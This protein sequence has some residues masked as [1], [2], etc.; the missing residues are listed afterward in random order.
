MLYVEFTCHIIHVMLTGVCG[1]AAVEQGQAVCGCAVI[2]VCVKCG[3]VCVCMG[4]GDKQLYGEG[5]WSV[6]CR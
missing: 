2:V 1:N 3:S 5:G 6:Y 4:A